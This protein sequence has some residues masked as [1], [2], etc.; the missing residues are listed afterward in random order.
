VRIISERRIRDFWEAADGA[1]AAK[2]EKAMREWIVVV[3]NAEWR[4]FADIRQTFNHS[5]AFGKCVIFDVGGNKYRIIA[6]AA[7]GIKVLFI[8]FVVTH[9]EYDDKKWQAD[10]K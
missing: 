9:A 5:D 2:R 7:F 10:C 8:R 6:K 4:N 3:K 1:E